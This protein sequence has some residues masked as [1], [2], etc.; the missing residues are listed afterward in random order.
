MSSFAQISIDEFIDERHSLTDYIQVRFSNAFRLFHYDPEYRTYYPITMVQDYWYQEMGIMLLFENTPTGMWLTIRIRDENS[1]AS[2]A[3][4]NRTHNR[5]FGWFMIDSRIE[6][7]RFDQ[8]YF[9]IQ[10]RSDRL[11]PRS[12]FVLAF[13][14]T[15]EVATMN[16]DRV[17]HDMNNGEITYFW[18]KQRVY[19]DLHIRLHRYLLPSDNNVRLSFEKAVITNPFAWTPPVIEQYRRAFHRIAGKISWWIHLHRDLAFG[20]NRDEEPI[21]PNMEVLPALIPA[22]RPNH[23]QNEPLVPVILPNEGNANGVLDEPNE[24]QVASNEG[25]VD[26]ATSAL[27]EVN[28]PI[29]LNEENVDNVAI[30]L[31]E[32]RVNN[33]P[34]NEE[35]MA[36]VPEAGQ[37]N[38]PQPNEGTIGHDMRDVVARSIVQALIN[39]PR[40]G[41]IEVARMNEG[42]NETVANEADE[43]DNTKET[44][45]MNEMDDSETNNRGE[46]NVLGKSVN[47]A[48]ERVE[49]IPPSR[50][51]RMMEA[52]ST[53]DPEEDDM[54]GAMALPQA[55]PRKRSNTECTN[56]TF[57]S[58]TNDLMQCE[59]DCFVPHE[60]DIRTT[61]NDIDYQSIRMINI[62]PTVQHGNPPMERRTQ[63]VRLSWYVI[64]RNLGRVEEES[65][66]QWLD[67]LGPNPPP[68]RDPS[69]DRE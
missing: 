37:N 44:K 55:M 26:N 18:F 64:E 12:D 38:R 50:F 32:H 68:K 62:I 3:L 24:P 49:N 39:G 59:I 21:D 54:R 1:I 29:V 25:N 35:A 47:D 63:L 52:F 13:D 2:I 28:E 17:R 69:F 36:L 40:E 56:D 15:T 11:M 14:T 23:E 67:T 48:N 53:A 9:H 20:P 60:L 41:T 57:F 27:A 65:T 7:T 43:E 5:C 30:E 6:R 58:A 4:V 31:V 34:L 51:Q 19:V 8:D 45:E 46:A 22:H 10:L 42:M 16:V 61:R 33:G 66:D